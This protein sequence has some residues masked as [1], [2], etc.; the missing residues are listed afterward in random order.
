MLHNN[1]PLFVHHR[2]LHTIKLESLHSIDQQKSPGIVNKT[3]HT[4]TNQYRFFHLLPS[5]TQSRENSLGGWTL[6][7][8]WGYIQMLS[9]KNQNPSKTL[10]KYLTIAFHLLTYWTTKSEQLQHQSPR[11]IIAIFSTVISWQNNV[12]IIIIELHG[13]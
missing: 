4:A 5:S 7:L 13:W 11:S 12:N 10:R 3:F 1:I 9:T 2:N 8:L 6:P